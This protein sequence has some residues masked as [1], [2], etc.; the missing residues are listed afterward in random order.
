[1]LVRRKGQRIHREASGKSIR[2]YRAVLLTIWFPSLSPSNSR[3]SF[4]T[5]FPF[6]LAR[7]LDLPIN[8]ST[9][10]DQ[11]NDLDQLYPVPAERL[12]RPTSVLL[13]TSAVSAWLPLSRRVSRPN[14]V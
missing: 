4:A 14:T 11:L 13:P 2:G 1:M 5:L 9:T 12:A 10:L 8:H 3:P 7:S 6:L